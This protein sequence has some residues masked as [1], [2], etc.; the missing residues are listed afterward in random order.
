MRLVSTEEN[1][2]EHSCREVTCSY[3]GSGNISRDVK[4][5]DSNSGVDTSGKINYT[6][7]YD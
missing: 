4:P 7:E 5:S 6:Y 1:R 3:D 2:N